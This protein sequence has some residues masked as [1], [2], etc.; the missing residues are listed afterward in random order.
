[1]EN[2]SHALAAGVFTLLLAFAAVMTV[3]WLQRDTTQLVP[4][5][6]VTYDSVQGLSPQATVRYRGLSVGKVDSIRFAPDGKGAILVRIGVRADTP[7]T[8]TLKATVEMQGI[9][10][11]AYIDLDDDG[12]PGKPLQTS[13]E[14][15]ARIQMQP[16]LSER[17]IAR[18]SQLMDSLQTLGTDLQGLLGPD[19][20]EAIRAVLHNAASASAQLEATLAAIEPMVRQTEPL[21]R[22]LSVSVRQ[23]GRAASDIATLASESRGALQQLMSPEGVVAQATR[24]LNQ[25]Q[26]AV[27][28]L[29]TVSPQLGEITAEAGA[30]L[31]SARRTLN[32]VERAPQSLLFG[33]PRPRPGPGEAGFSG[34][35][36]RPN[37]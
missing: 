26:R 23:A 12:K 16:G 13:A 8:D 15:P 20:R 29:S 7:M 5:D 34:F 1:M 11:I 21:L 9:T 19:N 32:A 36:E 37:P 4:Y 30:T 33:A 35:R 25:V 2:R 10:G 17:L 6:L 28:G 27:A 14:A 3:F 31:E 18:A 22:D 24:S